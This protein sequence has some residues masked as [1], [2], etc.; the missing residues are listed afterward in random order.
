MEAVFELLADPSSTVGTHVPAALLLRAPEPPL[1]TSRVPTHFILLMDTSDSMNDDSKLEN[2]KHSARL[3][4]HFLGPQ[5][6]LSL[7]TFDHTSK[8]LCAALGCSDANKELIRGILDELQTGG[9]TNLSS[10][11]A[12]VS[13]VLTQL[14]T[15]SPELRALKTGLLLLTDGHANRGLTG[16][17]DL[18]ALL[19]SLH[20]KFP[21]LT[22]NFVGYGTDHNGVLLKEMAE[23]TQGS[24]S[25]IEHNEGAATVFGDML[26]SLFSCVA[27]TVQVLCPEGTTVQ[28]Q[29]SCST[30][31][32]I[33]L[34]DLYAGSETVLLLMVP[35]ASIY[36][37]IRVYGTSLPSLDT[38]ERTGTFRWVP[39][40]VTTPEFTRMRQ[41]I[42]LTQ[43]RHEIARMFRY[44]RTEMD[45]SPSS[46][47]PRI[48]AIETR[49]VA[50]DLREN[51]VVQ[52]LREEVTSL[53]EA[54]EELTSA[55]HFPASSAE[56]RTR[57]SQ[58]E[59]F[60][61]LGRGTAAPIQ[62]RHRRTQA[63]TPPSP[64]AAWASVADEDPVSHAVRPPATPGLATVLASPFRSRAQRHV[65]GLMATMSIRPE[66][67]DAIREA[68]E[69]SRMDPVSSNQP[70][71]A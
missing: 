53:L 69:Y 9:S 38:F 67:I 46:F 50:E 30:K 42:E 26:G 29:W 47:L 52:M 59:A 4:L 60:V 10:G 35:K 27:Q 55:S 13:N 6:R 49:L 45:V 44:L 22:M 68:A 16:F 25:L 40:R 64:Q 21:A 58:H 62:S 71:Q 11:I 57:L 70:E 17:E 2:V 32:E 31:G 65:A 7:L 63:A 1:E 20:Q 18:K 12:R 56:L 19:L 36:Q 8:T 24:Y 66:D 43:L 5:D 28:G 34:G 48:R 51:P 15:Q 14:Y 54:I 37:T 3:V 61:G 23:R 41:S 39:D 33:E